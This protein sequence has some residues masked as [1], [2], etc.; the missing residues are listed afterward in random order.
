MYH[1]LILVNNESPSPGLLWLPDSIGGSGPAPSVASHGSGN[2][3]VMIGLGVPLMTGLQ[4]SSFVEATNWLSVFYCSSICTAHTRLN[5]S[6]SMWLKILND[7]HDAWRLSKH[8]DSASTR[9]PY[10]A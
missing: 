2:W 3:S 6:D 5:W 7:I 9:S 1:N 4:Q 10:G 8:A